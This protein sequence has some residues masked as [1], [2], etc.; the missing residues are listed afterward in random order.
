MLGMK[1]KLAIT[2]GTVALALALAPVG[3][4]ADIPS[5]LGYTTDPAA[6]PGSSLAVPLQAAGQTGRLGPEL[7]AREPD[8]AVPARRHLR[9]GAD[10][11]GGP[12]VRRHGQHRHY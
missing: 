10:T 4:F 8:P 3:A 7:I 11:A 5:D 9:F 2:A 12:F 6:L 1:F